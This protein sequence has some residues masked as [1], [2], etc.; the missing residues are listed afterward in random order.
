MDKMTS[1]IIY[2]IKR[3][4]HSREEVAK[5]MHYYTDTPIEYYTDAII[6]NLMERTIVEAIRDNEQPA[7]VANDYFY[8]SREPWHYSNFDAICAALTNIQVRRINFDTGK[9]EYINGFWPQE[10]FENEVFS[11]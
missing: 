9:Y 11:E 10:D 5:F 6:D 2:V 4:G 1:G 3:Y 7:T 8:W